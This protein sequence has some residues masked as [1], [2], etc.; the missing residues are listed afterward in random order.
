MWPLLLHRYLQAYSE[1]QSFE[2]GLNPEDC[3]FMSQSAVLNH[4]PMDALV[5]HGNDH[6][7]HRLQIF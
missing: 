1:L 6:F 3:D 5:I 7:F 2:I 4:D